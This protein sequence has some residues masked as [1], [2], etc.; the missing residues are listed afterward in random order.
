MHYQSVKQFGSR[1]GP[2][3]LKTL[4]N[5]DVCC[6]YSSAL[7]T[8]FFMEEN[9]DPFLSGSILFAMRSAVAQLLEC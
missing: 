4:P 8:R 3:F 5:F 6:I 7:E 2:T 1:S 9:N